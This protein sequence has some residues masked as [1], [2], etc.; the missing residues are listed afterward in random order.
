MD[1]TIKSNERS[2]FDQILELFSSF[3]PIKKLRKGERLVLA[4][5]M[6][7]NYVYRD[8]DSSIRRNTVFSKETRE[9]MC[10]NLE[11]PRS[12]FNNVTASLRR[13]GILDKNNNLIQPLHIYP[14]NKFTF[15][16]EFQ[17]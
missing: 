3:N 17:L 5:I 11:L 4:E 12:G 9:Q 6:Y 15:K 8:I 1:I 14:E 2:F 16:V 7:Q 10:T 13:N